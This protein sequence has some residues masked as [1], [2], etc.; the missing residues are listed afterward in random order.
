[1]KEIIWSLIATSTIAAGIVLVVVGNNKKV[2]GQGNLPMIISGWVI[3]IASII[4]S[5]VGIV[6]GIKTSEVSAG[7]FLLTG[8]IPVFIILGCIAALGLG[9]ANLVKGYQKREDGSQ[10][11]GKI[12]GGW[13]LLI[14]A[15]LLVITIIATLSFVFNQ[16]SSQAEPVRFM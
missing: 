12:I 10:N 3:F 16:Q 5:I 7:T 14:L 4:A 1:M 11:K 2:N 15:L 6:I 8:V 9:I 13:A